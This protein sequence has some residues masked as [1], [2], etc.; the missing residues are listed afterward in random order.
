L[1]LAE[2]LARNKTL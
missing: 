2:G 1:Y